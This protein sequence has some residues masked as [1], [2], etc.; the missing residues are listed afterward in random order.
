MKNNLWK[1][2]LVIGVIVLFVG[3]I[4]IPSGMS[5][6]TQK[7]TAVTT[8]Q[9]T[10]FVDDSV[11]STNQPGDTPWGDSWATAFR[12]IQYAIDDDSVKDGHI[13]K[14][15]DGTYY[16]NVRVDKKLTLI[17]GTI[18]T[19]T[20]DGGDYYRVFSVSAEEVSIS[21]FTIQNSGPGY[22]LIYLTDSS[23]STISDN[24]I[25]SSDW[26]RSCSPAGE[27]AEKI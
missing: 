10:W 22:S 25:I 5:E 27:E 11:T 16:E 13:I 2:G 3:A 17:G 26:T 14:V 7:N 20:V 21:G 8:M 6:E 15:G 23:R 19:S 12:D 18:G 1:K 9:T 24:N 4:I